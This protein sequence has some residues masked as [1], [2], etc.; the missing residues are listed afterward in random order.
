M[1]RTIRQLY[2]KTLAASD[3]EVGHIQDFY[4]NDQQWAVRYVIVDTGSWL[5]ER[6][7]LL[8][9]HAFRS[10]D[11]KEDSL[12][13][14]LTRQQIENSPPIDSHKPVSRQYEE[15]YYRYYG[16]PSYWDGGGMWGLG[17]QPITPWPYL[18]PDQQTTTPG[19]PLSNGTDP[20]LRSTQSM[21][22]YHIQASDGSI[23][24][25]TD[26][27]MDENWVIRQLV[28]QTGHWF[29]SKEIVL[30][31]E[32]VERISYEQSTVYISKSK[33]AISAAPEYH[34][35]PVEVE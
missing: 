20:H 6:Q 2:G 5:P 3:G 34:V 7:V 1:M 13:V 27:V 32:D 16:W 9:P 18:M 28:I 19:A 21:N 10:F 35:S 24:H 11:Q 12:Q 30:S 23:G 26:F 31:Q 14:I 33:E 29:S 8:S 4:F 17:G 15:E 25:I 22:G